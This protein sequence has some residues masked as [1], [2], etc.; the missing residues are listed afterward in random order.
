[1]VIYHQNN[2]LELD[3][4]S[5]CAA[6]DASRHFLYRASTPPRRGGEFCSKQLFDPHFKVTY[7]LNKQVCFYEINQFTGL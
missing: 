3:H 7:Y 5:V 4:H 1:V 6:K 2:M